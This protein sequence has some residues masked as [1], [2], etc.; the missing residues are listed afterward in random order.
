M[1]LVI[2]ELQRL[3]L[4]GAAIQG[5]NETVA[6]IYQT[7]CQTGRQINTPGPHPRIDPNQTVFTPALALHSHRVVMKG[8][9]VF[10]KLSVAA[11]Q[12]GVH[13]TSGSCTRPYRSCWPR[14][15]TGV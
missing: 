5:Q 2:N 9:P 1:A 13:G 7:E 15:K 12:H 14:T 8:V 11:G 4:T 3:G 10:Q 6:D